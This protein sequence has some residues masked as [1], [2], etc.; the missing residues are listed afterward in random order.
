MIMNEYMNRKMEE[1]CNKINDPLLETIYRNCFRNT[2]ETTLNIEEDGK[3]YIITGDIEA[4]WL[5]DSSL[6]VM[7]YLNLTQN[8]E[9]KRMFQGLIEKQAIQMITDPYANAFN[10]DGDW[11]CWSQDN[12]EMGPFIWERKYEVDSLAFPLYLLTEYYQKTRDQTVFTN[13]VF[14]AIEK[15]L[16]TWTIEQNHGKLSEYRFERD[17]N[18]VTETLQNQG[19]G[20]PVAYTGM[21]WSGFRPSDDACMYHYLIPSNML[22]VCVLQ[23][24]AKLTNARIDTARALKLAE[25]IK[26][27]ILRHGV[28]DHEEFGPIFAYEVDGLGNYNLMDDANL[29]SLLSAAYF[30]F[31]GPDDFIYRN[32]RN[33]VLSEKNPYYYSGTCAKGVGSPHT[34]A[35]Y[36]W[37]IAIAMQGLSAVDKVEKWQ[38]IQQLMETHAGTNYMH[39]GFDVDHP[40]NFTRPWF[41]WAN[42]MFCLLVNDYYDLKYK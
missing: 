24:L 40:A 21:T 9:V 29:P 6:Q 14:L 4:M 22:A 34:P 13:S 32:T 7:P 2:W 18:L 15:I 36:I 11:S 17:S 30:G 3:T 8:P 16:D 23:R 27:G 25:Q 20:T 33:F 42:S 38:M 10:K 19:K 26:E 31:C 37:P 35:N 1:A 12:T 5:R 28:V 39:E 41:A